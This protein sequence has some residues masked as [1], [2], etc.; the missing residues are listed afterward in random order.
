MKCFYKYSRKYEY[1][2]TVRDLKTY[3]EKPILST[4]KK[5]NVGKK[6]A[7][8]QCGEIGKLWMESRVKLLFF[9]ESIILLK[10]QT[11]LHLN[12]FVLILFV[13]T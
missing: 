4:N 13:T 12:K 9:L 6:T 1:L 10:G 7:A 3:Y 5:K 11:F 8:M 2:E